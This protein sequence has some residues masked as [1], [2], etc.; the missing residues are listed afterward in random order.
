MY[1]LISALKNTLF[2]AEDR[3][4]KNAVSDQLTPLRGD[5]S[6]TADV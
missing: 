2:N 4:S 1:L 5:I 3:R 6:L